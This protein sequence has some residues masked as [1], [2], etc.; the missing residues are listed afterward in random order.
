VVGSSRFV[1]D[2]NI[3]QFTDRLRDERDPA[4][5][6]QLRWLLLEEENRFGRRRERL[7]QADRCIAD[8]RKRI[9]KQRAVLEGLRNKG[10]DA[11]SAEARLNDLLEIQRLLETYRRF[12]IGALG[13]SSKDVG[14]VDRLSASGR[15]EV[16]RRDW[17]WA[18]AFA[19]SAV[20]AP[21]AT[22]PA[23]TPMPP[24]IRLSITKIATTFRRGIPI[25]RIV[26]MSRALF[27]TMVEMIEV[28]LKMPNPAT[29]RSTW[30]S[31]R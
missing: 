14:S 12:I 8:G 16:C 22:H 23:S 17:T 20:R 26:A 5:R 15:P 11:D 2:L 21:P 29:T 6:K 30:W 13:S 10:A 18:P 24:T 28:M 19:S 1:S 4:K 27:M 7:D 3:A 25:D 31:L 9:A